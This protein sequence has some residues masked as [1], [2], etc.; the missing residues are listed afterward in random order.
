MDAVAIG[1]TNFLTLR[2]RVNSFSSLYLTQLGR[3]ITARSGDLPPTSAAHRYIMHS[4]ARSLDA[5]N[6]LIYSVHANNLVSG[7]PVKRAFRNTLELASG[8]LRKGRLKSSLKDVGKLFRARVR[9]IIFRWK[10]EPPGWIRG[11][12]WMRFIKCQ[13]LNDNRGG[14][15]YHWRVLIRF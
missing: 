9:W 7:L 2:S 11:V 6:T 5:S 1:L 14:N 10:F 15:C 12:H 4:A 13:L 8:F 3:G